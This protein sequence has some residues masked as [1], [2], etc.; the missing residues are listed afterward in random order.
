MTTVDYRDTVDCL[1]ACHH[2]EVAEGTNGNPGHGTVKGVK[3]NCGSDQER[4]GSEKFIVIDV[5]EDHPVFGEPMA[6]I[7]ELVGLPI[8]TR[9]YPGDPA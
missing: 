6:P 4:S 8:R 7:S 9:K 2:N 1:T 3:I 5:P